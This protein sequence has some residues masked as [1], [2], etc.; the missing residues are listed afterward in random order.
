MILYFF[1]PSNIINIRR[2]LI[3][4]NSI[5]ENL[6]SKFRFKEVKLINF[7]I[8]SPNLT[9]PSLRRIFYRLYQLDLKLKYDFRL[10]FSKKHY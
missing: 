10:L 1:N 9:A 7:E 8:P 4:N 5:N 6:Y 3:K 2:H